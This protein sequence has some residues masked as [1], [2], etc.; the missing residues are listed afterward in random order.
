MYVGIREFEEKVFSISTNVGSGTAFTYKHKNMEYLITAKHVVKKM[1]ASGVVNIN[2][3]ND[4]L[5]KEVNIY[6]PKFSNIDIAVL[7][8]SGCLVEDSMEL[9]Y[10]SD[11]LITTQDAYFLGYPFSYSGSTNN[12]QK[13]NVNRIP[14]TRK[15]IISGAHALKEN[16]VI[17]IDA[18]SN[19]GFSGGPVVVFDN[20]RPKVCGVVSGYIYSKGK[21]YENRTNV[22]DQIIYRENSGIMLAYGIH[23]AID[24]IE[25]I[26]Y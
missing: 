16:F 17:F 9:K 25:Q 19:E 3:M 23:H 26:A 24:I 22:V 12:S 15:G 6:Y 11:N 20:N 18:D 21:I 14:I 8:Y 5:Q 2:R 7:G 13:G 1:G 10:D 4:I